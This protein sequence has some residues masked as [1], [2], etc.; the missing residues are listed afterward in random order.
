[1]GGDDAYQPV[2]CGPQRGVGAPEVGEQV[3]QALE[4]GRLSEVQM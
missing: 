2:E 1:M 3:R 4:G